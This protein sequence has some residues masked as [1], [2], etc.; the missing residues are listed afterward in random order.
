M[1]SLRAAAGPLVAPPPPPPPAAPY[2]AWWPPRRYI[3]VDDL[4]PELGFSQPHRKGLSTPHVDALARRSMI[5]ERA[6]V[7]Q[8]V[9]GPTRNSFLSGRRP[10][11]TQA[12][13]FRSSFRD[14]PGGDSWT[15]L[16]QAFKQG[17]WLAAGFGK[18]YHPGQPKAY[19]CPAFP[20]DCPS[21]SVPYQP[22]VGSM[23]HRCRHVSAQGETG[24]ASGAW[25]ACDDPDGVILDGNVTSLAI[26]Q[27]RRAAKS[28]AVFFVNVGIHKPHVPWV[29][30]RRFLDAQLSTEETDLPLQVR[31]S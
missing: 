31:E 24:C 5:F 8:G 4:R 6:Y 3:V 28:G 18:T 20:G 19:D 25:Q 11:T 9:C 17:G 10:A 22:G 14:A 29:F 21:W 13:N 2:V 12:W 15:A 16:P 23:G 26:D 7:Q 30:P 1:S 27:M